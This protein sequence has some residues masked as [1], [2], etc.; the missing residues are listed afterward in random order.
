M[1]DEGNSLGR[2]VFAV[3]LAAGMSSR[4][5]RPKPL[6]QAADGRPLIR[7]IVDELAMAPVDGV[8]V[9]AGHHYDETRV[10]LDGVNARV[11]QN[12]AFADGQS[13]SVHTAIHHVSE[14]GANAVLFLLADQPDM[15]A[16]YIRAV[17]HAHHTS[18]ASIVQAK[19]KDQFGHPV[20]FQRELFGELLE[21]T[22][23]EGGRSV[24]R[25]HVE[26]RLPVVIDDDSPIDLDTPQ[27]YSAWLQMQ[28]AGSSSSDLL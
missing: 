11:I 15:K 19:Y 5:G 23:D 4:M 9:V 2:G 18:Q 1:T 24:I 28:R 3:I 26:A 25:R 21:T 22:G 7:V 12:L 17:L 8:I 16:S 20:L 10:A 6:L 13:T 27:T 14:L